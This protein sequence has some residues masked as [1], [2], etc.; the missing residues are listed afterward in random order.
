M[1]R[2]VTYLFLLPPFSR[3]SIIFLHHDFPEV[4]GWKNEVARR[5][6]SEIAKREEGGRENVEDRGGKG[7]K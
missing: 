3:F 6:R 7:V 1:P 2:S 4:A 5:T